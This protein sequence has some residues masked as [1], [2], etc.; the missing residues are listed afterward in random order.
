MRLD[1]LDL[2]SDSIPTS[3]IVLCLSFLICK[4]GMIIVC[5]FKVVATIK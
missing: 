2:I 5:I 4:L 1:C 3:C